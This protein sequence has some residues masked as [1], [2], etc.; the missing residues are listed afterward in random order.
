MSEADLTVIEAMER[1]GGSFVVAL[2]QCARRADA[3]NLAKLKETF[4]DYWQQYT[5][6][7]KND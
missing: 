3:T 2:A 1:Y 4:A 7:A 6:M 5:E